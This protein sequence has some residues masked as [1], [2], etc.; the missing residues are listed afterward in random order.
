MSIALRGSSL[1]IS[2]EDEDTKMAMQTIRILL[3]MVQEKEITPE[4][5]KE[6]VNLVLNDNK[7]RKEMEENLKRLAK[8]D[9]ADIIYKELK[10]LV[11]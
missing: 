9:S 4:L 6:K 2:G 7:L 1:V 5:M 8:I 11:K 10:E 3:D